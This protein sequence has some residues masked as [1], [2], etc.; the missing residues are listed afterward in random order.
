[1]ARASVGVVIPAKNEQRYIGRCVASVLAAGV[2]ADLDILVVDNESQDDTAAIA[3]AA[4]AR[5]LRSDSSSIGEIR[6]I[7]AAAVRGDFIA[8][9]DADCEAPDGWIRDALA[10]FED[11][12]VAAVAG[13]LDVPRDAN[14]VQNAWALPRRE[15]R[16]TTR[17][18]VGA[19]FFV[20]RATFDQIG[21]FDHRLKTG[22]D[23]DIAH[24]LRECGARIH[25]EPRCN[26]IH[27]GYPSTLTGIIDRQI[28][29]VQGQ[30]GR[31][32]FRDRSIVVAC[33]F[34]LAALLALS[35]AAAIAAAAAPITF[36]VS[37]IR[38]SSRT[39]TVGLVLTQ[40]LISTIYLVGRALGVAVAVT[41]FPYRRAYK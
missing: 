22:E 19:S 15:Q 24:R 36:M 32:G 18:V 27:H 9:I 41:R 23:T 39:L 17:T 30:F 13:H 25:P 1:V 7:G 8:Y 10:A 5:V 37:R 4:G 11:A 20:R 40:Y 12:E 35:A 28:W 16:S 31:R 38:R 6:N 2:A 33:G 29:Q 26:V 34:A 14:W 21:G 3:A